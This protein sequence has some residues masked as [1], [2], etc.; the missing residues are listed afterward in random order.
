MLESFVSD[1]FEYKKLTEAEQKSRGILGRLIGVIA[2]TQKPTRNGR[3]YS[4]K[5]WENVFENP[6]M[7][8]KIAN[9]CCFGELNHPADRSEVDLERVAICLAEYP[10][11][12]ADGRL[13]GVFDILS[14]PNGRILKALCDYGCKIG[15][16]SRGQGDL[17]TD[18]DGDE[19]VD[20]DT[21][22]CECFDA[23][24]VPGVEVARLTYV[25]ESL[26]KTK[27]LSKVLTEELATASA[28]DRKIMEETLNML[29]IKVDE[30][31]KD[32]VDVEDIATDIA[33]TDAADEVETN[34]DTVDSTDAA[35][36][37]E[38]DDTV[39]FTDVDDTDGSDL[40]TSDAI[41][42]EDKEL[43]DS[44]EEEEEKSDA[45]IFLDFLANN[46]S[47]DQ[48]RDVCKIL[49]IEI[50]D[51]E[52]T[53]DSESDEKDATDDDEKITDDEAEDKADSDDIDIENSD[54][55]SQDEAEEEIDEAKDSGTEYLVQSLKETLTKASDLESKIITLQEE[56]AVRDAKVNDLTEECNRYKSSITRLSNLAK[57]NKEL[58][59]NISNL[60]KTVAE[61]ET[62]IESQ[63][64]RI[65]R[66]AKDQKAN[67]TKSAEVTTLT[68]SLSKVKI[69]Y[70]AKVNA[71][72]EQ[73][74]TAAETAAKSEKALT[75]RLD[76][77]TRLTEGYK[78]LA[79]TAINSYIE[80]KA[81]I[82][83][84]TAKDI[85]RKLGESYTIDDI[86]QVCE[87]LKSY[88][89]NVSRLPFSVDRKVSVKVNESRATN[90]VNKPAA[91]E[92]DDI[93]ATL[94]KL[95]ALDL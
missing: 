11:K 5:L 66:L 56:L 71:L 82:L 90:I 67:V 80:V 44:T 32:E 23:V 28:D 48:I 58:K 94:L 49:E 4:D 21:Y 88:N 26:E 78:K 37:A 50:E 42:F 18:D 70:E 62:L 9:R 3:K 1:A 75:E 77:S 93:D 10:K 79:N 20:P 54:E 35:E 86:N 91:Y 19:A 59:E 92:D 22:D 63:K 46:F 29:K 2:D 41:E 57:S 15:I 89:L 52:L 55:K 25:N 72:N 30:A 12:D 45:D 83:G 34:I 31:K 87:D 51:D 68:E 8:E 7:K 74:Q 69:D 95:A 17:I 85:K 84:L 60:E 36:T 64:S 24:I 39:V 43:S 27:P 65:T 73:L 61:K 16:S 13:H 81:D 33:D 6:I 40:D 38:T 76:K 14:T 47:E 53:L